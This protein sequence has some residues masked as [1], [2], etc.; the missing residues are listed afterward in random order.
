M[1]KKKHQIV[2]HAV[3]PCV[4]S[5]CPLLADHERRFWRLTFKSCSFVTGITVVNVF[6]RWHLI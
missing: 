3:R 4:M 1:Y 6:H 5:P 2:G